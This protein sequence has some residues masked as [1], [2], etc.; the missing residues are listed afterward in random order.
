MSEDEL[1]KIRGAQIAMIFQDPLSS[2]N[3]VL[4]IGRQITEAIETHKGVSAERREEARRS[5]CS[6]WSASRAPP[7]GSTT[8]RTS[9]AAACASAR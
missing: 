9:S 6:S 2:L 5:S 3:P 1:R 8:T 7:P 4:T